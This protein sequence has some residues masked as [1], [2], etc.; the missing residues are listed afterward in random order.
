MKNKRPKRAMGK[1]MQSKNEST[2]K[3][4]F[5]SF[6]YSKAWLMRQDAIKKRV[7]KKIHRVQVRKA[8][9]AQA[10]KEGKPVVYSIK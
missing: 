10:L 3:G 1:L 7:A 9:R 2:M 8:E 6:R 5:G 4:I